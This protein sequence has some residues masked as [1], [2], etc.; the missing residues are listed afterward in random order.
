M[1]SPG[2]C[3]VP[4]FLAADACAALRADAL[5]RRDAGEF[6]PARVGPGPHAVAAPGVRGD[7]IRW[8][9][10]D[11]PAPAVRAALDRCDQLRLALNRTLFLGLESLEAHY[12]WYP[13]GARYGVHIDRFRNDDARVLSMV[14]Y[15]ND[16]WSPEDGGALRLYAEHA[17]APPWHDVVPAGGTLVMF[18]ADRFAHEVLPARV[19]RLSLTGWFRRRQ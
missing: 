6:R 15:L 9:D 10:A 12:A 18:L 2:W 14:L 11:D 5:A 8:L 1:A 4:R 7:A 17:G 13:P 16:A 19:D 3:V